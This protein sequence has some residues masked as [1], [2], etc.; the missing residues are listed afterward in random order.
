M[1]LKPVS[2]GSVKV[3]GNA[4]GTLEFQ[5]GVLG[6]VLLSANGSDAVT[7]TIQADNSSGAK[8][9]ELTSKSPMFVAGPIRIGSQAA[10]YAISG[11][12]GEAQLY[13]WVE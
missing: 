10:Y 4:T 11:S 3:S 6:A 13:E 9:F 2:N 12:G 7:I 1:V 8:V 5:S